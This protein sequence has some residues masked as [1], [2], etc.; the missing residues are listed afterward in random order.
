MAET[1]YFTL[2]LA[3]HPSCEAAYQER[4]DLYLDES[5]HSL[6]PINMLS[7]HSQETTAAPTQPVS[8][9]K[10]P[11][12]YKDGLLGRDFGEVYRA[13]DVSTGLV[14]AAKEFFRGPWKR[15]VEILKSLAHVSIK[16]SVSSLHPNR[17]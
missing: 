5:H 11:I 1:L 7:L 4:L 6:G 2:T 9:R 13:L 17:F 14:Y 3:T 16:T 15:E 8:P 12:Y 10:L